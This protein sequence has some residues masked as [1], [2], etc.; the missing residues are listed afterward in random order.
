M[1]ETPFKFSFEAE[2]EKAEGQAD[3]EEPSATAGGSDHEVGDSNVN[4]SEKSGS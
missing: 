2:A 1:M 4:E 3:P